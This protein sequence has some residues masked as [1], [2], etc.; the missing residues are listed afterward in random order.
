MSITGNVAL[1]IEL[2]YFKLKYEDDVVKL[3]WSTASEYNNDYFTIEKSY[4]GINY[5]VIKTVPGVGNSTHVIDY[6]EEDR[7]FTSSIVYYR[8][9]QTDFDG[10]FVRTDWE[11][12]FIDKK[13]TDLEITPNPFEQEVNI[14]FISEINGVKTLN[15]TDLI[16][17]VVYHE[18]IMVFDGINHVKIKLNPLSCGVYLLNFDKMSFKVEHY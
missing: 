9:K 10:Q 15:L 8:L 12:V 17:N 2:L 11:S 14:T 4:D 13:V 1:P 16:G 18:D 3:R 7:L 6:Y 5:E